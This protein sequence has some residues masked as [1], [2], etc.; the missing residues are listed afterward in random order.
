[1][2]NKKPFVPAQSAQPERKT[3]LK[4]DRIKNIEIVLKKMKLN[5]N[6]F[7]LIEDSLRTYDENYLN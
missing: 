6:T 7:N 4:P 2:D 1:V 3:I 5:E